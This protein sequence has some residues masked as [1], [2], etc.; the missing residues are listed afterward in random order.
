QD[1]RG[2]AERSFSPYGRRPTGCPTKK[3]VPTWNYDPFAPSVKKS[4]EALKG[5]TG[6]RLR[7]EFH[8]QDWDMGALDS[9]SSMKPITR[10]NFQEPSGCRLITR[11]T[12]PR[13][14]FEPVESLYEK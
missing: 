11:N 5:S 13:I 4:E 9:L 10:A 8:W 1:Y 6:P 12:L 14:G 3:V 2:M 7:Y